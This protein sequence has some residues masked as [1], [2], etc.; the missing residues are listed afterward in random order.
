VTATAHR[1][2]LEGTAGGPAAGV[3]PGGPEKACPA[4]R[5]GAMQPGL[6]DRP[7]LPSRH[8]AVG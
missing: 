6:G 3:G 2:P 7:R 5:S 4:G 8:Y 1:L